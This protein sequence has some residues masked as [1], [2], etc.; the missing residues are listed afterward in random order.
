[1]TRQPYQRGRLVATLGWGWL[2]DNMAT[3]VT[4]MVTVGGGGP[5]DAG[6][7]SSKSSNNRQPKGPG[8]STKAH[9]WV[10]WKDFNL[11]RAKTCVELTRG[12]RE[13][14]RWLILAKTTTVGGPWMGPLWMTWYPPWYPM[15]P[16]LPLVAPT[17]QKSLPYPI[18]SA[19]TNL[20]AH[21]QVF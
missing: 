12:G 7:G 15:A 6:K 14:P 20:D 11:K 19:R 3:P 8:H 5:L 1:M 13:P 10:A 16:N 9:E 17:N 18:Y 4:T 21:V 2:G